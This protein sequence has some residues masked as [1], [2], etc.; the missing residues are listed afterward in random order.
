MHTEIFV[1]ANQ[2]LQMSSKNLCLQLS[3]Q[4]SNKSANLH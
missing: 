1:S 3:F 4:M 2:N